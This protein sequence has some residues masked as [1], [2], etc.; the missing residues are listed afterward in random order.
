[1]QGFAQFEHDVVGGIHNAVNGAHA[2]QAQAAL[3]PVRAGQRFDPA[4]KP[5]HKARVQGQVSDLDA[6]LALDA[7]ACHW[8]R[9]LRHFQ[10]PAGDGS[11]FTGGADHAGIPDHVGQDRNFKY[12][13]AHVIYQGHPG[14][15]IR[16]KDDHTIVFL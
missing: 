3:H 16:V 9:V 5:E 10:L 2:R 13:I 1:M 11:H 14:R 15:G 12:G 4:H 6:D 7:F 8:Q